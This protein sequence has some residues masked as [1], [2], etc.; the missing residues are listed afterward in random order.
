MT[1]MSG[2]I[3]LVLLAVVLIARS[4]SAQIVLPD[5]TTTTDQRPAVEIADSLFEAMDTRASYDEV[6]TFL[7]TRPESYAGHWRAARAALVMGVLENDEEAELRWLERADAHATA[8]IAAD[9]AGVDGLYWSA[10]AKGRLALQYGVRG[11]ARLTQEMWD[12][13]HGILEI[14]SLHPGAHN[15]LGK[16]NYEVMRLSGWQRTLGRLLL[17]TDPLR[18]SSWEKARFHHETAVAQDS[19]TILFLLDLAQ[20]YQYDGD[21]AKALET[22]EQALAL[23]STYP[24]DEEFKRRMR[25]WVAELRR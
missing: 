2:L 22:F 17:R 18:E 4:A 6:A 19:T 24:V 16:L 23:P 8:A 25:E 9:S 13:T 14:D 21:E 3:R 7:N 10:S 1:S 5:L 12:L 11:A 15:L 20:A